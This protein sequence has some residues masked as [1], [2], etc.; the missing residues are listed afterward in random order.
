MNPKTKV[1]VASAVLLVLGAAAAV[2]GL[3]AARLARLVLGGACLAALGWWW[4]KARGARG[5]GP[6]KPRLAVVARTGLSP[7]TGLA[8]VEVD[9]R[10]LLV[11]H[12]DGFAEVHPAA[13]R[14]PP[15]KRA[16]ASF[17]AALRSVS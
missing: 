10:T 14:R 17:S 7:R 13:G 16:R 2:G 3:D 4:L 11:V 1:F 6:E 15:R 8:L 5:A 12:G 9:G